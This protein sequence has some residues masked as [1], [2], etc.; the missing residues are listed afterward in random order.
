M[1]DRSP[2]KDAAFERACDAITAYEIDN[3]GKE[4]IERF[5]AWQSII[6]EAYQINLTHRAAYVFE[7]CREEAKNPPQPGMCSVSPWEAFVTHFDQE[8]FG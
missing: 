3:P 4:L 6:L 1:Q 7:K 8:Y 5:P 2:D